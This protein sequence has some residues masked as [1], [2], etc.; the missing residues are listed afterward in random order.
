MN[1][2]L[3]PTDFSEHAD[4]ALDYAVAIA[5]AFGSEIILV[6][7]F[8]LY[9]T[10]GMFTSVESYMEEDAHKDLAQSIHRVRPKLKHGINIRHKLYRGDAAPVIAQVADKEEVD[11]IIMGTQ[12]AS[13]LEE[14]FTGSTANGVIKISQVPV[15]VIPEGEMFSTPSTIVFAIDHNEITSAEVLTPLIKLAKRFQAR[16]E[17][18]HQDAGAT[19][20]GFAAKL[21]HYLDPIEASYHI[22]LDQEK[23]DNSIEDFVEQTGANLLCMIR[24]RRSFLDRIFHQSVTTSEAFHTRIPLLVLHDKAS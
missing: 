13:G 16:V 14:I 1:K 18:F 9:S 4:K 24:R 12:G 19:G 2:I 21:K 11:I 6:H 5:N 8:E 22:R 23:I 17:V 15:L 3:V 7:T 10:T 20:K